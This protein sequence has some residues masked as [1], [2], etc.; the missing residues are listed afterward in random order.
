LLSLLLAVMHALFQLL[1]VGD[2]RRALLSILFLLLE[3]LGVHILQVLQLLVQGV[4]VG[5][6]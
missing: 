3:Q 4:L 2:E 6:R 5:L 1:L